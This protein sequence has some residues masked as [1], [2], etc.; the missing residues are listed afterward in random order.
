MN[1]P[2]PWR[3][4]RI[5]KRVSVVSILVF[6]LTSAFV[7]LAG[8]D[9]GSLVVRVLGYG[10]MLLVV[11]ML[12]VT[13]EVRCPQC[14]HR[15]YANG[16]WFKQMTKRCLHCEQEKYADLDARLKPEV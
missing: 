3:Y 15:F 7:F 5:L 10:W 12:T 9:T 8:I 6:F 1:Q 13:H 2:D 16:S 4:H 14:G 11:V